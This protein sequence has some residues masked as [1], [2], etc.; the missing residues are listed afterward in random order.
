MVAS[1]TR[2]PLTLFG[3][4]HLLLQRLLDFFGVERAEAQ[5]AGN[6][7]AAQTK[8]PPRLDKAAR[9][10]AKV[11]WCSSHFRLMRSATITIS[12]QCRHSPPIETGRHGDFF[13]HLSTTHQL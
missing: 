10:L 5:R 1:G 13:R 2:I 6:G 8:L 4:S 7:N 9:G 11:H 3:R 12:S